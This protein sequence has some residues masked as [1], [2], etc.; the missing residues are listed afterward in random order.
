MRNLEDCFV[1]E[2]K[3][4][5]R[6]V[7]NKDIYS[8]PLPGLVKGWNVSGTEQYRVFGITE[9]H[10]SLLNDKIVSKLPK[11][12]EAKRRVID[13]ANR[14]Y[15]KD[16][17]GNYIYE[18]YA[19]PSGSTVVLSKVNLNLPYKVY[20]NPPKGYGYVDFVN[21]KDGSI[22]Y[23]Y[24]IPNTMLYK[25]NQTALAISVKNMKNFSGMGYLTWD[26]GV[27]YIHV[28]PYNP[29]SQYI[30]SKI[31]KTGIGLDYI[32]DIHAISD[33]WEQIGFIPNIKLSALQSGE[34]LV[35]KPTVIGYTEYTAVESI[36]LG[37]KEV[38][39]AEYGS[40]EA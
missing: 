32:K 22:S 8:V 40:E 33:H 2:F 7:G 24:V 28:I 15:K 20:L 27:I 21:E 31:L 23:I 13:K 19:V 34:N 39:G 10:F 16:G 25:I 1:R 4:E 5:I 11:G 18:K 37:A 12:Y 29:N 35:L 6:M 38:Y 3:R 17:N 36:C 30:G 14:S 9:E 26:S